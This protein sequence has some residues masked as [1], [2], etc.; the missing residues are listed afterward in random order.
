MP[1][2]SDENINNKVVHA[3]INKN[4]NN[5]PSTKR[6]AIQTHTQKTQYS[7]AYNHIEI[8]TTNTNFSAIKRDLVLQILHNTEN[9]MEDTSTNYNRL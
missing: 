8:T 2:R 4:H 9:C 6:T 7:L 1:S 5:K 3:A